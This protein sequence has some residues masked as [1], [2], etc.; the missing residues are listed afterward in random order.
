[1]CCCIF[2]QIC[3]QCHHIESLKWAVMG[4]PRPR[5]STNPVNQG[6]LLP[7]APAPH[8]LTM[9]HLSN[10]HWLQPIPWGCIRI[11]IL[12]QLPSNAQLINT[13]AGSKTQCSNSKV[14]TLWY[15]ITA[16]SYRKWFFKKHKKEF[17]VSKIQNK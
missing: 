4:I 2:F 15:N 17:E 5:E 1:M 16:Y 14:S 12:A 7:L 3:V 10:H 6:F 8:K 11:P 9:E 13:W